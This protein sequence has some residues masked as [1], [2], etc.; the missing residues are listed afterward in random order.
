MRFS[1]ESHVLSRSF[2]V[3]ATLIVFSTSIAHADVFS[4]IKYTDLVARLGAAVPTGTNIKVGQVEAPENAA[5]AY[6]P[7]TTLTEFSG[8]VFTLL[9]GTTAGPSWHGTEVGK[10]LYGNTLSVAPGINTAFIWN[11]NAWLTSGNLGVGTGAQPAA[12]PT[13]VR[14]HNHSWIGSFGQTTFDNEALRRMDLVAHRD[15][16]LFTAGVNNGAGS[17]PQPL[18]AYAYNNLAVGLADGNHA[19]A[20]TPVGIDGPNRRRPEIVAPGQFTSFSTPVVGAAAALLFDTALIDPAVS[21]NANANRSVTVKAALMAGTTHRAGWSNGAPTSGASR[22]ITATPLDPVYGAD[23]LN[24]D[25]AHRIFTGG[26]RNGSATPQVSTFAPH[27]G[28]DYIG[29]QASGA[30][31]YYTFRVHSPVDEVSVAAT[32]FR[33]VPTSFT[34]VTVQNFDLRLWRVNGSSLASISG[35]AGVGVFAS[36]NVESNSLVDNTEHLYVRN[37]AAGDY[38][39]ELKRVTGT[40][41]AMPVVVAWYM[42]ETLPS[43]DLNGDGIVGAADL[44]ILLNQWGTLGTADLN[45]DGIVDAQDMAALLSAWN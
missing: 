9:S 14:V 8:T 17:A 11:V 40:Q 3:G 12:T 29:S 1:N 26:E 32:W 21:S 31:S 19:A 33:N 20:P 2:V 37:L 7:N 44:A 4:D 5:G 23:L 6:A 45:G 39:L 42:P 35:E 10:S 38:V 22:G 15:N 25:R 16:V 36:G 34:S 41:V 13:G 24:V 43:T 18:V 27:A 30:S 28:W